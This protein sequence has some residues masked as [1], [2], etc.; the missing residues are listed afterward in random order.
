[1]NRKKLSLRDRHAIKEGVADLN[2][3]KVFRTKAGKALTEG[4]LRLKH[5]VR[6]QLGLGERD[7]EETM[8][9]RNWKMAIWIVVDKSDTD[10][11]PEKV[12]DVLV[13]MYK[14]ECTG[15]NMDEKIEQW[16][17]YAREVYEGALDIYVENGKIENDFAELMTNAIDNAEEKIY[18]MEFRDRKT[19][20]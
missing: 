2:D 18:E 10:E 14:R 5:G 20:R 16:V 4:L 3:S 6:T 13:E 17:I 19:A 11:I 9:S 15:K 7:L 1:M 8:E 12:G